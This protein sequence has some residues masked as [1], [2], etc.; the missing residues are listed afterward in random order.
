MYFLLGV[1]LARMLIRSH[2]TDTTSEG[3]GKPY[4]VKDT[5]TE[6]TL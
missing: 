6:I 3:V 5:N 1:V 2:K 4:E